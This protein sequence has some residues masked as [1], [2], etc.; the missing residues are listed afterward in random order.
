MTID[1]L[2]AALLAADSPERESVG[3]DVGNFTVALF[4]ISQPQGVDRLNL[5]GTGTLVT[6]RGRHYIL[7]AAHVWE[8]VLRR[9]PVLGLT[10]REN[11]DHRYLINTSDVVPAGPAKPEAWNEW[12]PDLV[13]LRLPPEH[14][15]TIEA[16]RTFYNLNAAR[17]S[18]VNANALETRLLMGTP[19]E[20]GIFTQQH[21][22]I[23]INALF[24]ELGA[25]A[26]V[27]GG[28]DYFDFDVD[29]SFSAIPRDFG[30]VSGGGLWSVLIYYS[31]QTRKVES[32]KTLEGVAFYQLPV[33]DN[34]R[35]I[36]CHGP[37]SI[38]V[39]IEHASQLDAQEH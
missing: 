30:G 31:E 25:A 19:A 22:D 33:K 18:A 35:I 23:E 15:G 17:P 1:E 16:Y 9:A 38:A 5:A 26:H 34:H 27:I 3:R 24:M 37:Q 14:V 6:I 7:T 11:I 29:L 8:D 32:L 10:L 2:H 28:F 13:L 36:R 39:A 20:L 4:A 21:A 12:G